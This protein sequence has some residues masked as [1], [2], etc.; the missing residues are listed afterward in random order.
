M[1]PKLKLAYAEVRT[2]PGSAVFPPSQ[3]ARGHVFH[4]SEIVG[5][6]GAELAYEVETYG[7]KMVPEGFQV[8]RTLASYVHLHFGSNPGFARHLVAGSRGRAS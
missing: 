1:V 5:E 8:G 7:G 6:P 4:F 3:T 2:R